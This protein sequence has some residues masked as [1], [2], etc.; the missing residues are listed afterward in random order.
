MSQSRRVFL[1]ALAAAA[2][3]PWRT[4]GE[5]TPDSQSDSSSDS[6]SGKILALFKPLPGINSLKIFA[7]ATSSQP[8]LLVQLKPGKRLFVGSVIKS[9]ILCEL[10]RQVDSVGQLAGTP[11]ALDASVWSPYSPI[12]N[13]PNLIGMVSLRTALEAMIL[14]SD[15]TGT[16]MSIF[17]VGIKNVRSFLASI[18]L[19][20]T[21]VPLSTRSFF[22]YL[23]GAPNYKTITWSQLEGYIQSNAPV[24]N[25]T[26]NNTITLASSANDLVSYYSRALV[27]DF[28]LDAPEL[29]AA[30]LAEFLRILSLAEAVRLVVP[31]GATGFG[32]GGSID[33]PADHGIS[34][35]GG[36]FFAKRWVFC[37]F[38]MNW[39]AP[40]EDDKKTVEMWLDAV[41]AALKLVFDALS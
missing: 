34:Y 19:T 2:T 4:F 12:L 31:L 1:G 24:V 8:E 35:A 36:M 5:T 26:L 23:Y 10:L 37:A 18:G 25:P 22:G 6:L 27:G 28:F 11:L 40:G 13:P 9:F 20:K 39:D 30:K 16:D 17:Q 29:K 15:N 38:T 14:H 21:Q 32:K 3:A 7:P 33:Y 41:A